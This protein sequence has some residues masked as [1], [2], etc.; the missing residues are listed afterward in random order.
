M[1]LRPESMGFVVMGP[2]TREYVAHFEAVVAPGLQ[3]RARD[4]HHAEVR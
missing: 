1:E 3:T 2:T 4:G